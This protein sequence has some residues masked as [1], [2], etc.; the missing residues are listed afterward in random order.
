MLCSE[1][2]HFRS[3][4]TQ[5]MDCALPG[6][7]PARPKRDHGKIVALESK[8]RPLDSR[9]TLFEIES[10]QANVDSIRGRFCLLRPRII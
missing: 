4:S 1:T 10:N 2:C 9:A 7:L 6:L 5:C 3:P 8:R